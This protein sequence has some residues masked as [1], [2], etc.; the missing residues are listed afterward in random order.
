MPLLDT[1]ISRGKEKGHC[2][3]LRDT[4]ALQTVPTRS[5]VTRS[6]SRNF[7]WNIALRYGARVFVSDK[8]KLLLLPLSV[9]VF[10]E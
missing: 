3:R 2:G 6:E 7:T 9:L 4:R 5:A 10:G 8:Q 1:T